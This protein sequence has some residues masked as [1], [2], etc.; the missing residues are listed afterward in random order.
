M[1][2]TTWFIVIYV[3]VGTY[4]MMEPLVESWEWEEY[5]TWIKICGG[6]LSI[7]VWPVMFF[8]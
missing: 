6:L 2:I 7:L 1:S 4:I 5:P 3:C 8:M